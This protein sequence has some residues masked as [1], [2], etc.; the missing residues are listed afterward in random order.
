M[1]IN[2]PLLR[3]AVSIVVGV[4]NKRFNLNKLITIQYAG[5]L[6]ISKIQPVCVAASMPQ[7]GN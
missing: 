1:S 4:P 7:D 2:F 5:V 6:S 3:E